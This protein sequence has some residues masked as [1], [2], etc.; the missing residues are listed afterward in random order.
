MC[1]L[2]AHL[3]T[4]SDISKITEVPMFAKYLINLYKDGKL[5]YTEYAEDYYDC[6][7]DFA[8][9]LCSRLGEGFTYDI[10]LD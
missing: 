2:D 10:F 1:R 6:V 9:A 8:M 3:P 7:V 5:Y 4:P